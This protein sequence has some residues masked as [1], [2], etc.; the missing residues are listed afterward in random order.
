MAFNHDYGFKWPQHHLRGCA[1][2]QFVDQRGEKDR[3]C[4][5]KEKRN[6]GGRVR[7]HGLWEAKGIKERRR[8]EKSREESK[9]G[10]G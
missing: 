5:I 8:I 9:D 1:S 10:E 3:H 7:S 4:L 6:N 2:S